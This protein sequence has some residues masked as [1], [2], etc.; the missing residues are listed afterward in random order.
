M[1]VSTT[2]GT[3]PLWSRDGTSLA[4][5][6][7]D[8][9]MRVAVDRSGQTHGSPVQMTTVGNGDV[10][11]VTADNRVLVR[12]S[13]NLPVHQAVLTLEWTRELRTIVGPPTTTLPR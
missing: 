6:S 11:G 2:G 3:D 9:L 8:M 1:S 7:G 4:W 13:G 10:A 12:R 5:R